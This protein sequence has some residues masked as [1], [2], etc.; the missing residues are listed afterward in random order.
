M[1]YK[2]CLYRMQ[3]DMA[4]RIASVGYAIFAATMIALG[5]LSLIRGDFAPV[6]DPIPK[7]VPARVELVFLSG[8]VSLASGIGLFWQ[9]TAAPAARVLLACLLLWLL[10]F[11]VP[12]VVRSP[13]FG[14]FW[15]LFVTAAMVGGAWVL[16]TGLAS[17][18]DRR[19]LGFLPG[20]KGLRIARVLFGLPLIFFGAAHFIDLKDTLV[21]IPAWLPWHTFW[22]YFTGSA[23]IAAG[24]AVCI[25]VCAR[26]AAALATFQIGIFLLLVWL[27]IVAA[28]SKDVFQ[29]NETVLTVALMSSA[30]VVTD[31]YRG[32]P[33]LAVGKG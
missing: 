31:S 6:W 20:N 24:V 5:V 1:G 33:W 26:L 9:R 8:L 28:G 15:P 16:Y 18:W 3:E 10:I 23:F 7:D 4:M 12:A 27:P 19:Y 30:W 13:T 21:L 22:A 29:W 17:D 14:V 11:R 32:R 2:V 25:G